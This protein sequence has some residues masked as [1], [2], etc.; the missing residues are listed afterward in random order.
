M[1]KRNIL[2]NPG[3]ATTTDSVKL[4]QV[5]PDICH[6]E[7]EF[8]DMMCSVRED[9]TKIATKTPEEYTC[10]LFA[11]SGTAAVESVI[12]S[13]SPP[14]KKILIVN[15]GAY[16]ERM[17]DMAKVHE[18]NYAEMKSREY[19]TPDI[20]GIEKI[21]KDDKKFSSIAMVHH[22][23]TSGLLNPMKEMGKIA[24]ANNCTYIL[25]AMSSFAGMVFDIKEEG[26]DYMVSSSN[27]CIQGMPG[28][29][30]VI[31]KREELEKIKNY[32]KRTVYLDLY[33]QFESLEKK[34]QMQFTVPIQT[35]YALRQAIDEFLDEGAEQR[36]TRYLQSWAI[37]VKGMRDIGFKKLL[38]NDSSK[39]SGI[40]TTFYEPK[41]SRYNFNKMHDLL[42]ERGFTIYPGKI[43]A[44]NTFRLANLGA[45]NYKDIQRFLGA[46]KEVMG[47]MGVELEKK[48]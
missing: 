26:V 31:A 10:I 47:E 30:F 1:V 5:V 15:N 6:R 9:L 23:T 34:A 40:L 7:K 27:K 22:E 48:I 29:S 4:A 41:D 36:E 2:L 17:V 8:S 25:D 32:P 43:G 33:K 45:I 18:I 38:G 21:L 37:L 13:V 24:K 44:E 11:G 14:D 3:P 12:S 20:R 35:M 28:I 46:M 19:E 16:G 42:Y 39:E